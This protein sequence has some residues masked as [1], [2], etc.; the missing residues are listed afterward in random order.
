MLYSPPSPRKRPKLLILR[1]LAERLQCRLEGDGELTITSAAGIERAQPGELTFLSGSR[2][3]SHLATTRASAVIV[4]A[5]LEITTSVALLR[6]DE[7]QVAFARALELLFAAPRHPA[8]VHPTAIVDPEAILA[9]GV[10]VG[11]FAVVGAGARIGARTVLYPHV[12]VGE[13][14]VIGADCVL[15][16]H[17]SV[18]HHVCLGDRVLAEDGAVIGGEGFGFVRRTDGTH[19]KIPQYGG[20]VIEDDVEIG[21]NTIVDR[22]PV[23]ETRIGKGT[24]IDNLVQV[25]HGVSVGE[26]VLL[27]SQ[28]GIAGSCT[29]EDDVILAGQVGVAD[30]VRIGRGSLATAQTGIPNDVDAAQ[31]VSGYPAIA[32][33]DWLKSSAIFRHLPELKKRIADLEQRIAQLEEQLDACRTPPQP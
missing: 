31:K 21:A 10:A 30:H 16:A 7:P 23:G 18:R 19:H 6:A 4:P 3:L 25:A 28:V 32:N 5:S 33:R 27:A 15:H 13:G 29:I 9:P 1:E 22:P 17:V 14:V 12:V 11:A 24:K 26:R 8:G 2:Y 20:L